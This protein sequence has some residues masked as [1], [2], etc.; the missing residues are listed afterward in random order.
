MNQE[1][2]GAEG[3][4]GK[5]KSTVLI[6]GIWNMEYGT[7]VGLIVYTDCTEKGLCPEPGL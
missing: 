2:G 6:Y 1:L 3:R 7:E 5:L 4:G